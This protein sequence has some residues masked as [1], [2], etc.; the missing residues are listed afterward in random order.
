MADFFRYG[1][2]FGDET[3]MNF[4]TKRFENMETLLDLVSAHQ[5]MLRRVTRELNI[6]FLLLFIQALTIIYLLVTR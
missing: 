5:D 2:P 6:V 3:I 1:S 4:M